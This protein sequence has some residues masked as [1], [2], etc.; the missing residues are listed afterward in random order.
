MEDWQIECKNEHVAYGYGMCSDAESH[1]IQSRDL[2]S[3]SLSGYP[4]NKTDIE[5]GID[6]YKDECLSMHNGECEDIGDH[7]AKILA[8]EDVYIELTEYGL[9]RE[10]VYDCICD[11]AYEGFQYARFYQGKED[12]EDYI[13]VNSPEH[14]SGLSWEYGFRN[15]F[16]KYKNYN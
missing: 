8:T 14:M 1:R 9:E 15:T 3:T 5:V 2:S 7:Q 4:G 12:M 10:A 13:Y 6:W 11:G 16:D